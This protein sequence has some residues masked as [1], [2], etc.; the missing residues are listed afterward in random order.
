VKNAQ[1]D[2]EIDDREEIVQL[3]LPDAPL[4]ATTQ[5]WDDGENLLV[6]VRCA[7][8]S[9]LHVLK[10]SILGCQVRRVLTVDLAKRLSMEESSCP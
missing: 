2:Q 3:R 7:L 10:L 8:E 6:T 4:L 1:V 5:F 9:K